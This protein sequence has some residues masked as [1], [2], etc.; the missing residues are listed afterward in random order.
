MFHYITAAKT[1][2]LCQMIRS[3][4]RVLG[5]HNFGPQFLPFFFYFFSS[6]LDSTILKSHSWQVMRLFQ[7]TAIEE[8]ILE[9]K[10]ECYMQRTK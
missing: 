5:I 6:A 1:H 3:L 2:F 10:T 4:F 8:G 7:D 9:A